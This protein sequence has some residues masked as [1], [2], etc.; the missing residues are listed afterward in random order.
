MEVG[1]FSPRSTR[2][3]FGRGERFLENRM[4]RTMS[5]ATSKL[6]M[7]PLLSR[8]NCISNRPSPISPMNP[9]GKADSSSSSSSSVIHRWRMRLPSFTTGVQG[10]Q[11]VRHSGGDHHQL[12]ILQHEFSLVR[13]RR[14]EGACFPV[15]TLW[16]IGEIGR[17]P[18]GHSQRRTRRNV[19]VNPACRSDDVVA[20]SP[21]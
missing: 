11:V 18:V 13:I 17:S 7:R 6:V 20:H 15:G 16:A 4:G 8:L 14:G 19:S 1:N 21:V 10:M 2:I 9:S 3:V 12:V 5:V